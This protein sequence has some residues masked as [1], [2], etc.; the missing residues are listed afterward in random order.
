MPA[1]GWCS[2][3]GLGAC[4]PELGACVPELEASSGVPELAAILLLGLLASNSL[5]SRDLV[6]G[7]LALMAHCAP[8]DACYWVQVD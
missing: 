1:L 3:P 7:V 8:L 5:N 6:C 4:M 2:R